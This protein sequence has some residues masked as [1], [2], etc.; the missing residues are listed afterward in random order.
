[1][2]C[3]ERPLADAVVTNLRG[4]AAD[5]R[6]LLGLPADA[7]PAAV[8]AAVDAFVH[9]WQR[10]DRPGGVAADDVPYV[11]GSLWGEQLVAALGWAWAE[12]TFRRHADVPAAAVVS[13]DRALAVFPIHFVLA[14]A[15]DPDADVTIALAFERLAAGRVD[16]FTPGG[17]ANVMDV[18]HRDG[19][20]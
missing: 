1:M 17:F 5:G 8:V 2:D 11:M 16:G 20:R 15:T 7:T 18:V 14:C 13:A 9:R 3:A 12:V 4:C 19:P 6:R 10:G